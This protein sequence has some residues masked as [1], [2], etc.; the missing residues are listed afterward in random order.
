MQ[1]AAPDF[2]NFFPI[3]FPI[4]FLYGNSPSNLTPFYLEKPIWFECKTLSKFRLKD[5]FKDKDIIFSLNFISCDSFIQ[6]Y[7]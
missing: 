7:K 2:L 5:I 1:S 3:D 4:T 6:N